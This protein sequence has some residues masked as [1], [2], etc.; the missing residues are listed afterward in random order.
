MIR[1]LHVLHGLGQG[2]IQTF[3]MNVYRHINKEKVQFD[4]LV[5]VC[6]EGYTKEII[7]LGGRI[8]NIPSR[9]EG[10][11]KRKKALRAFFGKH[12][13]YKIVHLHLS[14]LSDIM[15]LKAAKNANVPVRIIHSHNTSQGG[16]FLHRYI[17]YFNQMFIQEY[18]TDFYACSD[19]AAKWMYGHKQYANKKFVIIKN[20]IDLSLFRFNS[21]IRTQLRREFGLASNQLVVGNIGRF[22]LQ[23]NHLF[24]LDI[25]V[26]IL[27]IY[28]DAQ[29]IL[30]GDGSLYSQIE[31]KIQSMNIAENVK[32]VGVR[33]DI[34]QL[35]SMFDALLMPSLYEGLP[36]TVIEAQATG[37]AC[38][39]SSTITD[40]VKILNTLTFKSLADSKISWC[41]AVVQAVRL[42]RVLHAEKLI[43]NAG[44][45]IESVSK[46]LEVKY[47]NQLKSFM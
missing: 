21:A 30:V 26:E 40:E 25:F 24:M 22:H 8:Y 23:K 47:L 46:I 28:P 3:I 16:F 12:P 9:R 35:L 41:K 4:F 43:S 33:N 7:S 13:E 18:A 10:I 32:L 14:S 39:L 1:V 36:V 19:L 38:I 15:S 45:D 42:G 44:Y 34:P 20:A 17:H 11:F 27:K 2:G 31:M 6:Q 5:N 37:L 29:L